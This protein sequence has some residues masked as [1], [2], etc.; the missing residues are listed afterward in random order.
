MQWTRYG[1][2]VGSLP[3][4]SEFDGTKE[5]PNLLFDLGC[6]VLLLQAV[7]L[8]RIPLGK[9]APHPKETQCV[10]YLHSREVI[11]RRALSSQQSILTKATVPAELLPCHTS[12]QD[13]FP[14]QIR[15]FAVA[16]VAAATRWHV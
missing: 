10:Y 1:L 13:G 12:C 8:S 15:V 16:G 11:G 3:H 5:I 4:P 14:Q 6:H 7:N 2:G 9:P